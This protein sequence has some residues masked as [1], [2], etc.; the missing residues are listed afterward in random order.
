MSHKYTTLFKWINVIA[1]HCLLNLILF[2]SLRVVYPYNSIMSVYDYRL[3]LVLF[4]L[5]WFYCSNVFGIYKSIL[6]H[7]AVPVLTANVA[8]L[9]LFYIFTINIKIILPNIHI[10]ATPLLI[11]LF[12]FTI[13]II[14]CR[15]SFLAVRKYKKK[16]WFN[17]NNIIIVGAGSAGVELYKLLASKPQLGENVLGLFTDDNFNHAFDLKI[18][19][20]V[21]DCIDYAKE[22]NVHEIYCTLP[23]TER[24]KISMLMQLADNNFIRFRLVPDVKGAFDQN[25]KVELFGYMP[26]LVPRQEPLE[27]KANEILKRAFDILFSSLIILFLLSWLVPLLAIIIKADSKGPVFFKQLRSGKNNKP[28]YCI[29]FRSMS[30][31]INCDSK[32]ACKGDM[33]ITRV[34]KFIRKT[35]IDELPQF[36]NVLM[37]D[38]S[39]VGPRPHMLKHTQDYSQLINN[40]MVRHFLTPGI[41]G[42][43]QVLGYR[44]E[45]KETTAML[46]RVQADIWYLENWSLVLDLK[47]V[48]MTVR[49]VFKGD[50]NAF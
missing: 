12:A 46:N 24:S 18:L 41:T 3:I 6:K 49:Q 27:N 29:K 23:N 4:N 1:D 44:G 11:F 20:R 15:L 43:A 19:G 32:Q 8:S 31:N 14:I 50:E 2:I 22:N 25:L 39:V 33:R 5:S 36:F 38:M 10:Y 48:L 37:G 28:F 47:I 40:Y 16:V 17:T 9:G 35:S 42:W 13:S 30:V 7:E 26:V 34:G 21:D 45:T